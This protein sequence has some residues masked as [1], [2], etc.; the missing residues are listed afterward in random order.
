MLE[1]YFDKCHFSTLFILTSCRDENPS[2]S[3]N[4]IKKA[5]FQFETINKK[6]IASNNVLQ[7]A[8]ATAKSQLDVTFQKDFTTVAAFK[9]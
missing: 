9:T 3:N 6:D 8:S 4:I 2:F 1:N 7:N 5:S